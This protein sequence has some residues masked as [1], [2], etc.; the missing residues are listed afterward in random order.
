MKRIFTI[1]SCLAFSLAVS[2]Q[3]SNKVVNKKGIVK[4]EV[5]SSVPS[6][7]QTVVNAGEILNLKESEFN[8]GKIPQGKP[9]THTF[10]FINTGKTPFS[11]ENVQASCGC[12]TPEWTKN[13]VAPGETSKIEVGFNAA[14]E[15]PFEKPV[16][17]TYNGNQVK[18]IL[19]KGEVF[20]TPV[21][22]A[23]ENLAIK[24]LKNEQ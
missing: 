22:P 17:I 5:A 10:E 20:K 21:T 19:I 6:V 15:G 7:E 23:P 4:S 12:T 1:I 16:T 9:V 24:S 13:T 3:S 2:A 11:L 14:T 18:Q 8:F